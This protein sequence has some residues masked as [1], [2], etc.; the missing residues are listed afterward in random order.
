V[1]ASE[2][3]E[4]MLKASSQVDTRGLPGSR[5]SYK[6]NVV[7]QEYRVCGGGIINEETH[8]L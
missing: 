7:H 2:T 8:W 1:T 5:E 4:K 3:T 6:A